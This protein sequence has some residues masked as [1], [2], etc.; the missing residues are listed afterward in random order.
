MNY[1]GIVVEGTNQEAIAT[2]KGRMFNMSLNTMG[3]E[4][5]TPQFS[6]ELHGK[7]YYRREF[8]AHV[9]EINSLHS[10]F[11]IPFIKFN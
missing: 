9:K 7:K 10:K 5:G 6:H 8:T 4:L 3:I 11:H 2:I 1:K